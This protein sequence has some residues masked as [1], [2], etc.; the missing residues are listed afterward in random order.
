MLDEDDSFYKTLPFTLPV[1]QSNPNFV[2]FGTGLQECLLAA[3]FS[4]VQGKPGLVLDFEKTYGSC[5]KTVTIKELFALENNKAKINLYRFL[6]PNA[7][8]KKRNEDF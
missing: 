5:L 6:E 4:K 7:E 1:E 2:I 8:M 3:H